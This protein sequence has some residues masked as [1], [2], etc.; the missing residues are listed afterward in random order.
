MESA[1]GSF[2]ARGM[3][4]MTKTV[5]TYVDKYNA[6]TPNT[7]ISNKGEICFLGIK[8]I[9]E[10]LV[11]AAIQS[12]YVF[13]WGGSPLVYCSIAMSVSLS[14]YSFVEAREKYLKIDPQ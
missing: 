10:D 12:L 8:V 7:K 1:P 2:K 14:I 5:Q 9:F 3:D 6:Q 11:Q 4:V 13:M